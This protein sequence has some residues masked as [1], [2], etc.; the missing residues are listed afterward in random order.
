MFALAF[1][2]QKTV[3]VQCFAGTDS[4]AILFNSANVSGESVSCAAARFSRRCA[5]EDVPGINNIFGERCSS[6][7]SATCIGVFPRRVATDAS[8]EDCNGVKPPSGV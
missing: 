6:H 2:H 7:A 3:K 8:V 4:A 1:F 5:S